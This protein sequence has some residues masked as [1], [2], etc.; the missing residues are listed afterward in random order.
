MV[1]CGENYHRIGSLLPPDGEKPK[2]AQLYIFE[3]ENEIDNRLANFASRDGLLMPELLTSLLQMLDQHN[4]LVKTFRR[5]RQQLQD[6]STTN[7]KLRIFGA[8]S[9]NR[10]Y[11]LPSSTEVVAL[12]PGDFLP[13]RDDRDIIVDHVYE[14]LKRITS[15]NPKSDA[16][17]F[18]LLFPY[19]DDG[20]HPLIKYRSFREDGPPD[21]IQIP[22][23][24]LIDPGD[25]SVQSIAD[26]IYDSFPDSHRDPAYLT[27]RAIVTPTNATVSRINNYMLQ[28]VPG[29]SKTYYSSDS[30]QLST[31]TADLFDESYPTEF[32]N[33]LTFNGVPEHELTLKVCTPVMLLRNLNPALG[34][35]N[36]TRIMITTLGDNFIKGNIMGGSYDTDEVIIPRI[37]LNVENS[38]WPFILR[39][40][41][42]PVRLCYAMTINKSQGQT[43]EKV[44]IYL[45]EPVFSHGQLYVGVS[46]VKSAR[47][48]RI[49]IQNPTEIPYDFTKN[50]VFTEAF[51]DIM[52]T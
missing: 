13:D 22:P 27:S 24:F 4:Q 21:W 43:L 15:L 30:L 1:I 48:L 14:G 12:I 44:G 11:D 45:P 3:P 49:L 19:G 29:N 2:F 47:G 39:R 16:L 32:L 33:I 28:R 37:V 17:H 34:L 36:S 46:R 41:Q 23:L 5:V 25:D 18:P 9:R 31:E 6:S 26:D 50:I 8:K 38:K 35:C 7:L 20:Y 40:R 52:N 51:A 10:Q 42:F